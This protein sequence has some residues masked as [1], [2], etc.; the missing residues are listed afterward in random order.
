VDIGSET[1]FS[2]RVPFIQKTSYLKVPTSLST[3]YFG[4]TPLASGNESTVNGILTCR[5][6]NSQTAPIATADIEILVTVRGAENLEFAAPKTINNDINFYSVQSGVSNAETTMGA[7]SSVDPNV[8]LVYMGEKVSSLR[9]LMQRCNLHLV[10]SDVI[11]T[12]Q[13]EYHSTYFNRR[14]LYRGFDTDGVHSATAPVLTTTQPFN[15]VLN[16]PYHLITSCFLGERGS[17]TWKVDLDSRDYRSIGFARSDLI[18]TAA[19]YNPSDTANV[20]AMNVNSSLVSNQMVIRDDSCAGQALY[21]QKT[22]TGVSVNVPMYSIH[23]MLDT[24]PSYRTLGKSLYSVTDTVKANWTTHEAQ[25]A[26]V[27]YE[28]IKFYFQAGPDHSLVFFLNVPT[29]YEYVSPTAV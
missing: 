17:I 10:W 13:S 4:V 23:T 28:Q 5:V 22:N 18:K 29:L 6:M 27:D 19:R 21:N 1:E 20:F 8:N 24:T 15:F 7:P 25:H 9:E 14:P 2:L 26:S 3:T 11:P 12:S 16:T